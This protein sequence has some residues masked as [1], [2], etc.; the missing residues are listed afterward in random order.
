MKAKKRVLLIESL[1]VSAATLVAVTGMIHLKDYVNRSEAVRALNQLGQRIGD[2]RKQ[3]G[4]LPP[5]SFID[6][7]EGQVEGSVRLGQLR[8]RALWIEPGASADTI[9]AYSQKRHPSSLLRDGYVVLYLDGRVEWVVG[10]AFESQLARQQNRAE[11]Q[12]GQK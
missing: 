5:Q 4:S 2:Y 9:L 1:L 10:E 11:V 3:H 12:A 8:Y 7:V 6:T